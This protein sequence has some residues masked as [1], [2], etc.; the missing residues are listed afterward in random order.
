MTNFRPVPLTEHAVFGG[1]VFTKRATKQQLVEVAEKK[2]EH[3]EQQ[4]GP[5]MHVMIELQ[6]CS[7]SHPWLPARRCM[8]PR[9]RAPGAGASAAPPPAAPAAWSILEETRALPPPKDKRDK[10]GLVALVAEV[11]AEGHST[12]VF[13]GGVRRGAGGVLTEGA[14]WQ[15]AFAGPRR[16]QAARLKPP[17]STSG[18]LTVCACAAPHS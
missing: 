5:C 2:Q 16:L 8:P 1:K 10:D 11:M 3:C 14:R 4:P 7:C 13:C 18:R 15:G 9:A 12:L 6:A 17:R